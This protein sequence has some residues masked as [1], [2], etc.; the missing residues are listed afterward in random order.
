[1]W[2]SKEDSHVVAAQVHGV[3]SRRAIRSLEY[4]AFASN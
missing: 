2:D 3:V 4:K 1:V